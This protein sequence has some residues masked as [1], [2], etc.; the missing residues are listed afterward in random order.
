[1]LQRRVHLPNAQVDYPISQGR[2]QLSRVRVTQNLATLISPNQEILPLS[3]SLECT[4]PFA[5]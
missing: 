3:L 1:M 2:C 4:F 5:A